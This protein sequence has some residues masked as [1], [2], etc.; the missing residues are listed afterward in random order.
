MAR[1]PTDPHEHSRKWVQEHHYTGRRGG[2]LAFL[3]VI[4]IV[5]FAVWWVMQH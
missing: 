5:G 2:P 4:A 1:R 3:V